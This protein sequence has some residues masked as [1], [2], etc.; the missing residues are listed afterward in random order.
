MGL[1][2]SLLGHAQEMDLEELEEEFA[3]IVVDGEQ[4]QRAYQLSRDLMVFTNKRL[5]L[6]DKEGMTGKK[7]AYH[8]LPYGTI[9]H[10]SK[11]YSG[12]FDADAKLIIW[13]QD[14]QEPLVYDF[15][16]DASIHEVYQ[17]LSQY[18]LA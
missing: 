2:S 12:R 14:Q 3:E 1:L 7:R 8:S 13:L 15:H 10:F 4:I 6:V 5:V 16:K 11:E 9:T 18:V 17:V